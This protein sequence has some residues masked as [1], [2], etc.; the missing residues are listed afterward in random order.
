MQVWRKKK[1]KK[2]DLDSRV[3]LLTNKNIQ[4]IESFF[5]AKFHEIKQGGG[6]TWEKKFFFLPKFSIKKKFKNNNFIHS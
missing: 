6:V 3:L 2:N 4:E 5:F 1:K